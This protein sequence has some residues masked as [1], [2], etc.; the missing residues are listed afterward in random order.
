M[1]VARR[2]RR[3]N[4]T[5]YLKRIKLLK[6]DKPRVV[7]RRSNKYFIAQYVKSKEAKDKIV[8]GIS[9]KALKK[10]GWP[11]DT[12]DGIK[13][14][15]ATYLFGILVGKRIQKEKLET[16]I[17]DLGLYRVLP[18]SKMHAFIKGIVDSGLE[19]K[20]KKEDLPDEKRIKG[21]HLK[22]KIPTEEIKSK[23][24]KEK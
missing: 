8:F 14:T 3:E 22:N 16:P 21:E 12:K 4:K 24:E 13:S 15:P 1:K 23:I 6:S 20:H 18:K 11:K 17:I 2:R 7:L 9:T 5:N 10:Y 19:I